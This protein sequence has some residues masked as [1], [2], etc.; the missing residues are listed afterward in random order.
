MLLFSCSSL[1]PPICCCLVFFSFFHS[2]SPLALLSSSPFHSSFVAALPLSVASRS[3]LLLPSFLLLSRSSLHSPP[4]S[5]VFCFFSLAVATF[6][7]LLFP[8]C[9]SSLVA[10]LSLSLAFLSHACMASA[11]RS[12][13]FL[14]SC[15]ICCSH[16]LPFIS[17]FLVACLWL[18]CVCLF[19]SPWLVLVVDFVL[20][21]HSLP[22]LALPGVCADS[23]VCRFV[24]GFV[25]PLTLPSLLAVASFASTACLH[26]RCL[27]FVLSAVSVALS[28]VLLLVVPLTLPSLLFVLLCLLPALPFLLSILSHPALPCYLSLGPCLPLSV[29]IVP[30]AL[31]L[32]HSLFLAFFAAS[33]ASHVACAFR[34]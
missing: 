34:C 1:L 25:L 11:S 26:L 33:C 16:H 15:L 22:S 12:S 17:L 19:H 28:V 5:F 4:C 18:P 14:P 29:F 7:S 20:C 9:H 30:L 6:S 27:A 10:A 2:L 31:C 21:F 32:P 24:C 3:S 23:C 8:S 13:L